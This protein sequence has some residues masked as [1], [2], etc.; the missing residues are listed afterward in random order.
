MNAD[1]SASATR[2]PVREVSCPV[3]G[4]LCAAQLMIIARQPAGRDGPASDP[5]NIPHGRLSRP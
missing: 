1:T 3:P 4:L 2:Q 5:E